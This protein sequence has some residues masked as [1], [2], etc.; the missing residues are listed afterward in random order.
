M[1][2]PRQRFG[3]ALALTVAT[4]ISSPARAGLAIQN[5]TTPGGTRV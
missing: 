1:I 3:L 5:W 2:S 4:L